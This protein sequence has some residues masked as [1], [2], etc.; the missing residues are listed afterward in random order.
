MEWCAAVRSQA[1]Y[2]DS[3]SAAKPP[4]APRELTN[5]RTRK[6]DGT[7]TPGRHSLCIGVHGCSAS[8]TFAQLMPASAPESAL[9]SC[10]FTDILPRKVVLVG[11]AVRAHAS[12]AP[13]EQS[14]SIRALRRTRQRDW[15]AKQMQDVG[16]S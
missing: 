2:H 13:A 7:K 11:T 6:Y 14:K 9:P 8:L 5:E 15:I 16:N 3:P 10:R 12:K 4:T 1:T